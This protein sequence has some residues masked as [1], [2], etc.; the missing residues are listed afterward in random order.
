MCA[1]PV[2]GAS[3][4]AAWPVPAG[5]QPVLLAVA[6]GVLAQAARVSLAAAFQRVQVGRLALFSP[7]AAMLI[8]AAITTLAVRAAG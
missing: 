4:T 2:I 8:A 6:A 1:S 7:A 5:A 3:L